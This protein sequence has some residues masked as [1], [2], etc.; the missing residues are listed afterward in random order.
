M[1][2]GVGIE[3]DMKQGRTSLLT[4]HLVIE[5][6]GNKKEVPALSSPDKTMNVNLNN[7]LLQCFL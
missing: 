2:G 5:R 4:N 6:N 7:T 1:Y 3:K